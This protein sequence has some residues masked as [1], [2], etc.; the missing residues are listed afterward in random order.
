MGNICSDPSLKVIETRDFKLIK[1]LILHEDISKTLLSENCDVNEEKL[2]KEY[3]I[4]YLLMIDEEIAGFVV[5]LDMKEIFNVSNCYLVDIGFFNKFRGKFAYRLAKIALN[6]FMKEIQPDKLFAKVK[7]TN[8]PSLYFAM[9]TGFK[10]IC[11]D[12]ETYF[13]EAYKWAA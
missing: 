6:K 7:K 13:L 12:N 11:R 8:K 1:D 10:I 9:E 2:A 3:A 4:Y 5:L